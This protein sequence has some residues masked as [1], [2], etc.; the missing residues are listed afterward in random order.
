[1]SLPDDHPTDVDLPVGT[2]IEMVQGTQWLKLN[3]K[4]RRDTNS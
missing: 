1:L 2:P 4:A 3:P